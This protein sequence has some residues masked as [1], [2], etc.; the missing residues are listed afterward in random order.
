MKESIKDKII[1]DAIKHKYLLEVC[2]GCSYPVNEDDLIY[3]K[4]KEKENHNCP[5]PCGTM[6]GWNPLLNVRKE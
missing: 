6:L 3:F 4:M 1:E 5:C 2:S